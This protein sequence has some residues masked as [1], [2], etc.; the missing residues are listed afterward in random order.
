MLKSRN[1]KFL[2]KKLGATTGYNPTNKRRII[3]SLY[4]DPQELEKHNQRL[5][6]KYNQIQENEQMYETYF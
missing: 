1:V 2:I 3:N 4:L 6:E 5:I